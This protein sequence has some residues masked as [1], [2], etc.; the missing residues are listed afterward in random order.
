MNNKIHNLARGV[1][2]TGFTLLVFKLL[3]TQDLFNYIAPKMQPF[4]YFTLI[5]L[6]ILSYVQFK[7]KNE[8][9][10]THC[11]CTHNHSYSKSFKR[12]FVM[13]SLFILP[14]FSGFLFSDHTLG[15]EMAKKKG[16]KYDLSASQSETPKNIDDSDEQTKIDSETIESNEE[17]DINISN[18]NN[19]NNATGL[20]G[21]ITPK[22]LYPDRY[23]KMIQTK[24][25][26]LTDDNYIGTINLLEEEPKTFKNK[27]IT[28]NGFVFREDTFDSNQIVVGRMGVSCCVADSGIFGLMI[29][30]GDFNAF[31]TDTW[32]KVHGILEVSQYKGW[33]LPMVKL[34]SIEKIDKPTQPY[35]YKEID[36]S[37]L[38]N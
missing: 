5:V 4:F 9:E 34:K 1:I 12:S 2:L 13:Y 18:E 32:V 37:S 7:R 17:T 26:I 36:Y 24:N 38:P 23:K 31:P 27:S 16:F 21:V 3:V 30:G 20:S 33:T 8:D 29:K 10:E 19:K 14:I 11:D 35:V 6:F 22:E 15:S 28:L 25:L